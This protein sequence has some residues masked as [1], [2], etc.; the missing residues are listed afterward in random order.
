MKP[1]AAVSMPAAAPP[2]PRR[3]FARAAPRPLKHAPRGRMPA[4]RARAAAPRRGRGTP[5]SPPG[6]PRATRAI[7]QDRFHFSVFRPGMDFIPLA[8]VVYQEARQLV[9][10]VGVE[11]VPWPTLRFVPLIFRVFVSFLVAFTA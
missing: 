5:G 1:A 7:A 8:V 2:R 9:S 4:R 11:P 6:P 3:A 10:Q